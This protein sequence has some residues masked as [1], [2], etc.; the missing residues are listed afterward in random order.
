M[1]Y[2]LIYNIKI[3]IMHKDSIPEREE[4]RYFVKEW[5]Q[6]LFYKGLELFTAIC[7]GL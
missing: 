6:T 1:Y 7:E 2:S 3:S 4:Y 5:L